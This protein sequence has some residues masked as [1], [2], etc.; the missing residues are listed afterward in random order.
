MAIVKKIDAG[1]DLEE[2]NY[3][4]ETAIRGGLGAAYRTAKRG[5]VM[6]EIQNLC[7]FN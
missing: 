7:G 2:A 1:I 6:N 5:T 3:P 4:D